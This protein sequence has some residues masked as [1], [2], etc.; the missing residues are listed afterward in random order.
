MLDKENQMIPLPHTQPSP[1][2]IAYVS[3]TLIPSQNQ[4]LVSVACTNS[5]APTVTVTTSGSGSLVQVLSRASDQLTKHKP[6]KIEKIYLL[7]DNFEFVALL[8]QVSRP[9][10]N[11]SNIIGTEGV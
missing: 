4:A 2:M 6:I 8:S 5:V 9:H 11:A 7:L 3:S 1:P 10:N